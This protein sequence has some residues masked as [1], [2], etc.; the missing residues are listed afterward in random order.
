ME[1]CAYVF[2]IAYAAS[3]TCSKCIRCPYRACTDCWHAGW[4]VGPLEILGQCLKLFCT[5]V[6]G[7]LGGERKKTSPIWKT[8][9]PQITNRAN[10][11]IEKSSGK[12]FRDGSH[13]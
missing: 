13:L 3:P 8:C 11:K 1:V 5:L 7:E 4:A 2:H 12:M 6:V 10:Q 9:K